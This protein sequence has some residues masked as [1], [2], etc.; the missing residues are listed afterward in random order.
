MAGNDY[1]AQEEHETE[2]S[3]INGQNSRDGNVP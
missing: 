3:P 1:T 2:I